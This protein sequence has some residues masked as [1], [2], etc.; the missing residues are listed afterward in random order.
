MQSSAIRPID[1]FSEFGHNGTSVTHERVDLTTVDVVRWHLEAVPRSGQGR[2]AGVGRHEERPGV[3]GPIPRQCQGAGSDEDQLAHPSTTGEPSSSW[4]RLRQW[5][6]SVVIDLWHPRHG[7]VRYH[8]LRALPFGARNAV[9]TFG[10]TARVLEHILAGFFF[11]VTAQY[12]RRLPPSPVGGARR[13]AGHHGR[14]A[15][16]DGRS[17]RRRARHRSSLR[18]SR[19]WGSLWT[20]AT[21]RWHCAGVQQAG[22]RTATQAEGVPRCD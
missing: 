4:R 14:G 9:F 13:R 12:G 6:P 17:R 19:C 16:D 11:V 10:P 1:D 3:R 5:P 2:R 18:K 15:G 21:S 7:E 20:S 8:M 22:E